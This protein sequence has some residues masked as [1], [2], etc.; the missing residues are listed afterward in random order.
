MRG[1][2]LFLVVAAAVFGI[3]EGQPSLKGYYRRT[4]Y[5]DYNCTLSNGSIVS[6]FGSCNTQFNLITTIRAPG[7]YLA[8]I[9]STYACSPADCLECER[10]NTH[11]M[12]SCGL[13]LYGTSPSD[14]L[15]AYA[16]RNDT[17]TLGQYY[18]GTIWEA[19]KFFW[20]VDQNGN[21]IQPSASSRLGVSILTLIFA[22]IM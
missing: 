19:Y 9:L 6:S 12:I 10:N 13:R 22:Q 4:R 20:F 5:L 11:C 2:S 7:P 16:Y 8:E 18:G 15:P 14:P 17:C 1:L 3:V 21:V